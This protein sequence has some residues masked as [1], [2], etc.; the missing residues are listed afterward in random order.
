MGVVTAGLTADCLLRAE[1]CGLRTEDCRLLPGG[2][3]LKK[4]G[5]VALGNRRRDLLLLLFREER[6]YFKIISA[7]VRFMYANTF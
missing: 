3:L 6:I 1:D 2:V 7:S 5:F 4:V